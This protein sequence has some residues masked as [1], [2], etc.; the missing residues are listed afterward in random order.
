MQWSTSSAAKRKKQALRKKC[1]KNCITRRWK[2]PGLRVGQGLEPVAVT[3]GEGQSD[4]TVIF[5]KQTSHW[6]VAD[7]MSSTLFLG[8]GS[9]P[10]PHVS[11][12]PTA[13]GILVKLHI[14]R[15]SGGYDGAWLSMWN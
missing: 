8:A 13:C 9:E 1:I 10:L 7:S 3:S 15:R 5:L 11:W 14:P 12:S 6:E 4:V 2:C